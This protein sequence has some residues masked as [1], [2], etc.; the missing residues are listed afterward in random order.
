MHKLVPIKTQHSSKSCYT[1]YLI[2]CHFIAAGGVPQKEC[3]QCGIRNHIRKKDCQC[4][5]LFE[6]GKRRFKVDENTTRKCPSD[7]VQ[8][9][10]YKVLSGS[11][12]LHVYCY[13][14]NCHLILLQWFCDWFTFII[15]RECKFSGLATNNAACSIQLCPC[16][17]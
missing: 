5:H 3:P 1:A 12:C 6:K 15:S 2:S 14:S 16:S 10:I 4:G 13:E 8:Q 9:M 7:I 11:T 17:D